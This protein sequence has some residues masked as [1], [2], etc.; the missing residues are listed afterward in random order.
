MKNCASIICFIL[1]FNILRQHTYLPK[2][3]R[4]KARKRSFFSNKL[5]KIYR[6]QDRQL[7]VTTAC[8]ENLSNVRR[9]KRRVGQLITWN[10][11]WIFLKKNYSC[12]PPRMREVLVRRWVGVCVPLAL[13]LSA[14]ATTSHKKITSHQHHLSKTPYIFSPVKSS[15]FQ[16]SCKRQPPVRDREHFWRMTVL[17]FSIVFNLFVLCKNF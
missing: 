5:N 12:Q 8:T 1:S 16:T 15:Q 10:Q 11:C 6:F 2:R 14:Y 4:T 17:L 9:N 13:G 3:V 7:K